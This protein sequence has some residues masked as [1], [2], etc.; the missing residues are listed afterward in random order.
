MRF[1]ARLR[2]YVLAEVAGTAAA[3]AGAWVA[4]RMTGSWYTSGLGGSLW[5]TV[6]YYG[7]IVVVDA[8]RQRRPRAV[9]RLLPGLLVEFGPAELIDTLLTRPAL[10]A[11]GPL[12]TG[13]PTT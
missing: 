12:V 1:P 5:E 2:R 4:Y 6:G 7:A 11:V 8:R 3:C 13:A 9:L 10:M